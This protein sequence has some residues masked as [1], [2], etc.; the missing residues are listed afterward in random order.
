MKKD[1]NHHS[2]KQLLDQSAARISPATLDKL[3]AARTHALEHHRTRHTAPALAWLGHF[4]SH[5]HSSHTSKRVNWAVAVLF[6]ACLISGA[7]YWQNSIADR[8][9]SE[10]DIAI[11]TDDLPLHAYVE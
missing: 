7:A 10:V 5:S 4:G 3:Q 2:V 9:T 8:D 11:L 6:V 1:L